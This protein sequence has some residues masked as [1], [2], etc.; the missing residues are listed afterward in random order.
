RIA[1]AAQDVVDRVPQ[2][3]SDFTFE[4]GT[5]VSLSASP[6]PIVRNRWSRNDLVSAIGKDPHDADTAAITWPPAAQRC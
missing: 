1:G 3:G 4:Q 6:D 2:L 5:G